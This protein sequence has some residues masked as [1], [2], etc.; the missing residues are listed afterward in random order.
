[1]DGHDLSRR[2]RELLNEESGS[3]WLDSR[4]TYDY[5]YE[6]IVSLVDRTGCLKSTQA[7]TTVA[8]QSE[9]NLNP[10]YLRLY[11]NDSRERLV[12]KFTGD[13]DQFLTWKDYEDIFYT[14]EDESV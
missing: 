1:M 6:A 9:Y 14:N 11:V 8:G 5:F 3:T 13:Y 12:I 10:D 7:I 4:T 2:L